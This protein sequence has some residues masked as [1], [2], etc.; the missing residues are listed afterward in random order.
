MTSMSQPYLSAV[1][2]CLNE[3]N[4]I[5]AFIESLVVALDRTQLDYEI[6]LVNDGSTDNTFAAITRLLRLHSCIPVALDLMKNTGQAAAITAGLAEARGSYVLMM[7]SDL[8]LMPDDVELFVAAAK[9]GAD[10]INGYRV[11]RQDSLS[12]K[13]PSIVANLVMRRVTGTK[14]KDFG[15]TYRL[16]NRRLIQAFRLG[17]ER[18]LSIPLL[19]SCV[20]RIADV[21][22]RHRA[23]LKG[24]SGW[25]F[26]KLWRYHTDNMIVLAQ[27]I[28]Q[29]TGF[30][31]IGVATLLIVR[32]MLDPLL[33][34]SL[35][36]SVTEGL[37]LNAVVASV[38]V[39][40]GLLCMVGE[41]VV[42]CHRSVL[43]CPAYVIRARLAREESH[44]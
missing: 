7:D 28:F 11:R 27:P 25:T 39:L 29:W 17:P 3:E 16:V 43:A 10:L 44:T 15:C 12:R 32:V 20:G 35:L 14:L 41:F 19:I 37:I 6:I 40:I 42:R 4:S 9:A 23:R 1:I 8:Q 21:P 18:I 31:S 38:L 5:E 13:L 24:K 36:G 34:W 22:V 26:Q 33:H 2:T 30:A